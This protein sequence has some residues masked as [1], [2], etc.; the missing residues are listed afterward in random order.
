MSLTWNDLP[1]IDLIHGL[2]TKRAQ[3]RALIRWIELRLKTVEAQ[4]SIRAPRNT[5]ARVV[6]IDEETTNSLNV[7]NEELLDTKQ[8]L[9]TIEAELEFFEWQKEIY[10]ANSFRGRV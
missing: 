9:D 10:K 1:D 8:Q 7:L 5:A 3:L 2:L 6:G 4:I